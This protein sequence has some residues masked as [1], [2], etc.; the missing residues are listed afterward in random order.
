M[1]EEGKTLSTD[2]YFERL[3]DPKY[4]P[5]NS[6]EYYTSMKIYLDDNIY[7]NKVVSLPKATSSQIVKFEKIVREEIEQQQEKEKEMVLRA[8]NSTIPKNKMTRMKIS[9]TN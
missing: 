5:R 3:K 7:K 2:Q 4:N 6:I 1:A 9:K 8:E